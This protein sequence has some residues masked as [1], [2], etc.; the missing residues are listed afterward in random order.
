MPLSEPDSL[1]YPPIDF[2]N[3][4]LDLT[5]APRAISGHNSP[6]E[7]HLHAIPATT[8]SGCRRRPSKVSTPGLYATNGTP[9]SSSSF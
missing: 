8:E 5:R 3:I 6:L 4:E 2:G 9:S 7:R 1:R